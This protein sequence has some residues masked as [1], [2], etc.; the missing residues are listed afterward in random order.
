MQRIEPEL[1]R[2]AT[3]TGVVSQPPTAEPSHVK[4]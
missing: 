4:I 2:S 1:E 3:V